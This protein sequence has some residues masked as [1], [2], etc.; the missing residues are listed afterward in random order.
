MAMEGKLA[1]LCKA[2]AAM[3]AQDEPM[4]PGT[5]DLATLWAVLG[6]MV[7]AKGHLRTAQAAGKPAG[8]VLSDAYHRQNPTKGVP[9]IECQ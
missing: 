7:D 2:R 6:A 9:A 5:Q 3:V 8:A 1:E 4:R